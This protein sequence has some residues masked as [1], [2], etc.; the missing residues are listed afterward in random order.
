MWVVTVPT[1]GWW[2]TANNVSP[3]RYA[4][5]RRVKAWREVAYAAAKA[6]RPHLPT[7]LDRVRV[8]VL[9]RW[10]KRPVLEVAN[11]APTLKAVIDGAIGPKRGQS[12]GYGVVV[13]DSD[14][15]LAYG[16]YAF[17]RVAVSPAR[18]ALDPYAGEVVLTIT[19][20][21]R[22]A[23]DTVEWPEIPKDSTC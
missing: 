4:Q 15:H 2:L 16:S 19:D 1:P 18:A 17:E 7:G 6:C 21:S 3:N 8:D 12:V 10:A 20:L 9:Y 13:D 22:T 23:L 14:R 5:G 11:L